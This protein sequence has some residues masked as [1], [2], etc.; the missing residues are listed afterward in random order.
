MTAVHGNRGYRRLLWSALFLLS[1]IGFPFSLRN[2]FEF[3]GGANLFLGS[4]GAGWDWIL[5]GRV[6]VQWALAFWIMVRFADLR[7]DYMPEETME[8]IQ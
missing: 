7:R 1:G 8:D 5:I 4:V 2:I 3:V 6:L